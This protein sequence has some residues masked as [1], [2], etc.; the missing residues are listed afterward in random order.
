MAF[1][2]TNVLYLLLKKKKLGILGKLFRELKITES[3]KKELEEGN[4]KVPKYI[5]VIKDKKPKF[6][7]KKLSY[8]DLSIL[9]TI[10]DEILITNDKKLLEIGRLLG[11]KVVWLTSILIL[12]VKKE[13]LGK[14]EAKNLL[15]LLILNGMYIRSDVLLE[16][17]ERLD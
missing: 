15:R 16:V 10:G 11:K 1:I 12:A 17:L 7:H 2:D 9:E 4:V 3:V 6:Q 14:E 5:K 13:I 8:V